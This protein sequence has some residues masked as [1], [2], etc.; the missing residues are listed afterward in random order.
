MQRLLVKPGL[1][2]ESN[3]GLKR[4]MLVKILLTGHPESKQSLSAKLHACFPDASQLDN[5][6]VILRYM[7]FLLKLGVCERVGKVEIRIRPCLLETLREGG[8]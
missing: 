1:H 2:R 6:R 3:R 4:D 5:A 8:D 7:Q